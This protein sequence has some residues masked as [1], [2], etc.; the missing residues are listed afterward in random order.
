VRE[1]DDSLSYFIER[2]YEIIM[3]TNTQTGMLIITYER[4]L[5]SKI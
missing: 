1:T 4:K 2:E 3:E 5:R